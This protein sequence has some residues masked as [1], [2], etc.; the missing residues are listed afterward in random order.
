[1]EYRQSMEK[2]ESVVATEWAVVLDRL[3]VGVS[4]H[5]SNRVSTLAGVSDILAGD[6]SIPPVLRAL[7]GEVPKL[8]EAIRLLRLLTLHDEPE[9]ASQITRIVDDA[10]ALA[11][12]HPDLKGTTFTVDGGDDVP[13]V[14]TRPVALTHEMLV[15]FTDAALQANGAPVVVRLGVDGDDVTASAGDRTMRAPS[16]M[17]ARR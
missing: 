14:V 13:P 3:L 17:A 5:I 6:P 7:S 16:L 10:I 9:E 15:A 11:E 8:E 2:S 12:L 1:M 4:H